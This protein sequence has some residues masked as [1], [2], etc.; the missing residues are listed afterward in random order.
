MVWGWGGGGYYV[1]LLFSLT[2]SQERLGK[3]LFWVLMAIIFVVLPPESVSC[4]RCYCSFSCRPSRHGIAEN[5][6]VANPGE[7]ASGEGVKR[8]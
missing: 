2:L 4:F 8:E 5:N 3:F 6:Q 7:V 1:F